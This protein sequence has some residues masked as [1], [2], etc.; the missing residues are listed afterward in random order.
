MNLYLRYF[1]DETLVHNVDEALDFLS[2]L[3]EINLTQEL[4]DDLREYANGNV[5]FPK[6]YKVRSRV[7]FIVIKTEAQTM[8]DF[9]DKKAVRSRSSQITEE[10]EKEQ[11]KLDEV[12]H[13]WYEGTLKFKRGVMN[14]LGKCEYRDT[15]FTAR[16]VAES[17]RDCYD[18]IVAHLLTRV[19][20]RSQFPTIKGNNFKCNFLGLLKVDDNK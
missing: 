4:A 19:D 14:H 2:S 9:K 8:Q 16:C 13:G 5:L 10:Q 15:T 7:Y 12:L 17:Q 1:D 11:R 6:R 20:K 3:S 18:K